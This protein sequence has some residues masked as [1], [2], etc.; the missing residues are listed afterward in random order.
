VHG[1]TLFALL[2]SER[3]MVHTSVVVPF[4][5]LCVKVHAR[6]P[7]DHVDDSVIWW[8]D[9]VFLF[10]CWWVVVV[11]D[12]GDAEVVVV[13]PAPLDG[14]G[15]RGWVDAGFARCGRVAVD[16]MCAR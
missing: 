2:D 6:S 10:G 9:E 4:L 7:S 8:F 13:E 16:G 11:V 5:P 15:K 1:T 14:A 12:L 3:D